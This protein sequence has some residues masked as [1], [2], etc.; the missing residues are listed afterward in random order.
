MMALGT[1]W[2]RFKDLHEKSIPG[3]RTRKGAAIGVATLFLLMMG[4]TGSLIMSG[5]GTPVDVLVGILVGLAAIGLFTGGL[6][7]CINLF[8][9]LHRRLGW[10]GTGASLALV[11][12]L[13][14]VLFDPI[15]PILGF[16]LAIGL[17]V[18]GAFLGGAIAVIT[19]TGFSS[20]G[21]T[22]RFL[23]LSSLTVTV[24]AGIAFISWL[25]WPGT[26]AHLVQED[27]AA[28]VRITALEAPDPSKPGPFAVARFFYGSGTDKHRAE[29]GEGV[30]LK[31]ESVDATPFVDDFRGWREKFWKSY[32]GFGADSFP[33]NGR[34]WLPEGEGPFSLV[35]I[36][37]GGHLM[38]EFSD[39]GFAYLGELLASRGFIAVSVDEN[40][41]NESLVGGQPYHFETD[42]RAWILLQHLKAW[43]SWNNT[44]GNPLYKKVDLEN[45]ALVGHSLGGEAV[46]IAG[47]F[48]GLAH[49]PDDATVGFDFGFAIKAIIAIAPV[50]GRRKP[51]DKPVVLE[52]VN[53]LT[54]H[55]SHDSDVFRFEGGRQYNR[56]RF[57]DN[58]DWFK[59]SLYIYRANHGQFNTVWGRTDAPPPFGWLLNLKPLLSGTEQRQIAKVYCSAFLETTLHS[60]S[61]YRSL[62]RDHRR[63]RHWLP[64]T[65]YVTRYED[66]SFHLLSD[67]EEDIDVTTTTVEA[68]EL[69]GERLAVWQERDM[70]FRDETSRMNHAVYLGW[71]TNTAQ[72]D[73][74][75]D[76]A[77][78]TLS[79]PPAFARRARLGPESRLVFHLAEAGR[80]PPE[81]DEAEPRAGK[82]DKAQPAGGDEARLDFTVQ[83]VQDDGP[84]ASLPLSHF[85]PLPPVL[86][87]R[88]TKSGEREEGRRSSSETVLQTYELPLVAFV[89]AERRF[90][91]ANLESIRF[92]FDR[93]PKGV[94]ILDR[95]GFAGP[96][97]NP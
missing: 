65:I 96:Y 44:P 37:H 72:A 82:G 78:Y 59:A 22:K 18:G 17:G 35:M 74:A 73:E 30:G 16:S 53:Y 66:A 77:S 67:F 2:D 64:E 60:D 49:S 69:H 47:A 56:V 51:S 9:A 88:F 24:A 79:F 48:N 45:I 87:T 94:I 29:Y 36:V 23:V 93:S 80:E 97:A 90:N 54:L 20:E 70:K 10:T 89:D 19:A 40:F 38:A 27:E 84:P 31:T 1:L 42:A 41:L 76:P 85:R 95:I 14:L 13:S 8:R 12:F 71:R 28:S 46:A 58:Q 32:W 52:N 91:P 15:T 81:P 33:L 57:T 5:L 34:A 68:G 26:D 55:G 61:R 21:I 83:L 7:F 3:K 50:D 63:I 11:L 62:F 39:P 92:R 86:K 6:W 43:R 75:T 25:A 4:L